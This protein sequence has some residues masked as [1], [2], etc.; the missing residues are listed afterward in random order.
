MMKI[1]Y[2]RTS[3]CRSPVYT[4][5]NGEQSILLVSGIHGNEI[6]SI[7]TNIMLSKYL[8]RNEN[9]LNGRVI[10]IPI[11]NFEAFK[12]RRRCSLIDGLDLNRCFPGREY[13]APT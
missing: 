4:F 11:A 7:L 8:K 6:N 5:G 3:L 2:I 12:Y 9:K 13:G 1:Q 10:V